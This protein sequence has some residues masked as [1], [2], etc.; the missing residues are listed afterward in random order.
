MKFLT[1]PIGNNL[2]FGIGGKIEGQ[3]EQIRGWGYYEVRKS[4]LCLL[5]EH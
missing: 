3:K 5:D 2:T 1:G 4:K